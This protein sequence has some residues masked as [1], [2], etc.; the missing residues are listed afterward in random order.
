MKFSLLTV[1][2]KKPNKPRDSEVQLY[3]GRFHYAVMN[4]E[5]EALKREMGRKRAVLTRRK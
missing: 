2:Q 3:D 1:R 5:I 4:D